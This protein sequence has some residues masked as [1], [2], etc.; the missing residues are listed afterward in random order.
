M[1]LS[2]TVILILAIVIN[3]VLFY[4]AAAI[5]CS[6]MFRRQVKK[7]SWLNLILGVVAALCWVFGVNLSFVGSAGAITFGVIIFILCW[8]VWVL[9]GGI[10]ERRA[11]YATAGSMLIW[12]LFSWLLLVILYALGINDVFTP[13]E[14]PTLIG[15]LP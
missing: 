14:F 7:W 5:M 13:S 8:V 11:A 10:S 12:F 3:T 15:W 4:F 9:G 6:I 1:V 2:D